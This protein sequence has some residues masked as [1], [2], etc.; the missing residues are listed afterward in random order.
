MDPAL[1]RTVVALIALLASGCL[2]P[3]SDLVADPQTRRETPLGPVIGGQGDFGNHEWRGLPYA[4]PPRGALRWRAPQPSEAWDEERLALRHPSMCPQRKASL[5]KGGEPVGDEDC[6]YA[7]VYAPAFDPAQV[8]RDEARLPVM[9]WIHG[10]G[11]TIGDASPYDGGHLAQV[12]GLVIVAVNYRLGPFGWFRHASL[13]EAGTSADDHSGNFGTLDLIQ[14]LRWVRENISAFGGN[15]DRVTIFG[16][17]AGG[18]N[19]YSL[20]ASPRAAGLFHGAVVQS[21]ALGTRSPAEAENLHDAEEP[22]HASSS[23]EVL[24][25]LWQT[26]RG[27]ADR[28][29]ARAAVG[30][31]SPRELVVFLRERSAREIIEAY[32]ASS[33]GM[34]MIDLPMLFGDTHVLPGDDL[35]ALASGNFNRVPV[36]VGSNRDEWKLFMAL[37]PRYVR[38]LLGLIPMR[39]RDP[40]AYEGIAAA[41]SRNWRLAGVS[42]PARAMYRAQP[43]RVWA[44]RFDWDDSPRRLGVVNLPT[45]LGAAHA[46]EIAFVLG[47][48]RGPFSAAYRRNESEHSLSEAMMSYWAQFAHAGDPGRGRR[49]DLPSWTPWNEA[50]ESDPRFIVFDL[51]HDGGLRMAN[52]VPDSRELVAAFMADPRL[53]DVATR[54]SLLEQL[55]GWKGGIRS[56][57]VRQAGC[58]GGGAGA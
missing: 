36:I 18:R 38:R 52:D 57:H 48:F 54:C 58:P 2:G 9:L 3:E 34:G 24:L 14:A 21:G 39:P 47:D 50:H 25:R 12:H 19:V 33:S 20:L 17:S 56:D 53:G 1:I 41:H 44:Y 32:S 13:R 31:A 26:H 6:L 27:A 46:L 22:G 15:P 43:G 40:E 10:G 55:V 5:R 8:P 28:E 16:E 42:R 11:N 49:G 4:R 37:D 23:G 7:T 51:P 45:L 35:G 30:A 29:A